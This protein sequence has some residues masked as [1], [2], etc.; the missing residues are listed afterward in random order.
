MPENTTVTLPLG[1]FTRAEG[2][3]AGTG[4]ALLRYQNAASSAR[5]Q[6]FEGYI[7]AACEMYRQCGRAAIDKTP[8]PFRVARKEGGGIFTGRFTAPA[9]PDFQGTLAGGLSIVFEAKYTSTERLKRGALTEAQMAALALH[10]GLG[11][12]AGV[13]AGIGDRF[14]FVPW[15]F[16]RDMKERHGRLYATAADLE[17]YRVRFTGAVLFLD[18][19]NKAREGRGSRITGRSD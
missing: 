3:M 9:Q 16:W 7:L 4:N 13:C 17:P 19:A 15:S 12:I 8:E 2:R 10:A 6:A 14:F 18:Y 1:D 11:A 5:G